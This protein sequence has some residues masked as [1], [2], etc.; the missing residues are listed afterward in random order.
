MLTGRKLRW[1]PKTEQF[2]D[3]AEANKLLAPKMREPWRL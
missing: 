3:D 2:A 1:D